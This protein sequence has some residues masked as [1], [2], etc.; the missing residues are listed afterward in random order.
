MKTFQRF[1]VGCVAVLS[2]AATMA[3]AQ[4]EPPRMGRGGPPLTEAEW[5]ERFDAAT[6]E[7]QELMLKRKE[8]RDAGQYPGGP[9]GKGRNRPP[10]PGQPE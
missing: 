7:Q 4:T 5:Q 6:P 9:G 3:F 10:R 1:I 2:T 8:A